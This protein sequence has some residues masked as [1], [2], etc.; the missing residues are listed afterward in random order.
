LSLSGGTITGTLSFTGTTPISIGGNVGFTMDTHG[1][2]INS[3][4][5]ASSYWV[6]FNHNQT[7]EAFKVYW[8]TGNAGFA[9]NVTAPTFTGA[10]NGNASTATKATKDGDGNTISTEYIKKF[11]DRIYY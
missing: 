7:K 9:G 1:N 11:G 5:N 6:I 3:N 10:L 2:F 4:N 8:E